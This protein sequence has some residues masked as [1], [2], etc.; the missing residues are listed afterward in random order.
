V[1][2]W[3][4]KI[5]KLSE[6]ARTDP[7]AA[8]AVYSRATQHEWTYLQ[9]VVPGCAD[10]FAPLERALREQFIPA[11]FGWPEGAINGPRPNSNP[12]SPADAQLWRDV[13]ALPLREGGLGIADPTTTAVSSYEASRGGVQVL[14]DA[15]REGSGALDLDDHRE[16]V[17]TARDSA[18]W[19]R[20]REVDLAATALFAKLAEVDGGGARAATRAQQYHLTAVLSTPPNASH[21][22]HL[23]R[24]QFNDYLAVR[25][26]R[27]GIGLPSRCACGA[28][29]TIKHALNCKRGGWW[30]CD[31]TTFKTL[32]AT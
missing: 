21:R 20:V 6:Y 23:H 14:V 13:Y 27:P 17:K 15:L 19:T 10:A 24:H 5:G 8:Y 18:K 30:A 9:R 32:W 22:L 16:C 12:L 4:H 28:H 1:E 11:L 3:V 31:M 2:G 7:H 25:Y 29:F 26:D